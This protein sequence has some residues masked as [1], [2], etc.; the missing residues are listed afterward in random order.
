MSLKDNCS[1]ELV[2]TQI[3]DAAKTVID[4]WH[5][6]EPRYINSWTIFLQHKQRCVGEKAQHMVAWIKK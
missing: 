4:L 6:Y 1:Q 5:K 2:S 3:S